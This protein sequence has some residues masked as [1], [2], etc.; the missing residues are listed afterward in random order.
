MLGG[1]VAK[2]W[3]HLGALWSGYEWLLRVPEAVLEHLWD[4]Q[5]AIW[6]ALWSSE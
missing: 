2:V 3:G 6:G 4:V 1:M 5:R